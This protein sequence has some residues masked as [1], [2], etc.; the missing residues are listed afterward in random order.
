VASATSPIAPAASE[1]PE[2]SLTRT[3]EYDY[4]V[5]EPGSY[6]LPVIKP[7]ADGTLL[8][9]DGKPIRLADLSGGR[10]TILSFIYTRC[11]DPRACLRASGVLKQLQELTS[12]EPLLASNVVLLTLSFDPGFDTPEVMQRYGSIFSR[13]EGGADWHFLTAADR[14]ELAPLL[15]AY[16]QQ[17]DRAKPGNLTGPYNH[18]VRVYL[19]DRERRIRNI[20]TYGLLDPRLVMT[21]V[22]TLLAEGK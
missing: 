15:E 11:A 18:P 9:P 4:D 12:R 21:D 8:S 17:V 5:P 13:Q 16:G 1:R 19:I 7:A 20:Y 3:A 6:T 14:Q 22:R 2:L 10:I